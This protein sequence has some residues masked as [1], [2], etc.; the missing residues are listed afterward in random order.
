M[1]SSG[2]SGQFQSWALAVFRGGEWRPITE[3]G[4]LGIFEFFH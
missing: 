1:P 4:P 2:V 3:L